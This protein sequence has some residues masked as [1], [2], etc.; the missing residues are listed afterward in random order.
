[1]QSVEARSHT[2]DG[3]KVVLGVDD[4]PKSWYNILPDLPTPFP[5]YLHPATREPVPPQA[6]EPLFPKELIRQEMSPNRSEP[7]PE[8]V[9]EAY[10]RFGRP[11]PLY[12]AT[13]LEAFLKTPAK[14]YYKREDLSPVGSHKP[15]TAIAQAYFA[16]KE[17]I[18]AYATETG[19]GQWGSALA[20]ATNYFGPTAKV[21][22]ARVS[23]D[24]KPYRKYVM[25]LYGA[26]YIPIQSAQTNVGKMILPQGTDQPATTG[27]AISHAN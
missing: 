17:G 26:A 19:A 27:I 22:M 13:R 10:F 7:I 6:F 25:K 21:F 24:Q 1:M 11:T 20:L 9:R 8:E 5:P 23:Y 14:I 3:V 16:A 4:L 2:A 18:E 15:N 12:R